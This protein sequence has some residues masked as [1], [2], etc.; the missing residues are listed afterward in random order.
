MVSLACG[1]EFWPILKR[2]FGERWCVSAYEKTSGELNGYFLRKGKDPC[3][4]CRE[5]EGL[6][7]LSCISLEEHIFDRNCSQ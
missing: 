1:G 4:F 7:C 5:T 6:S 2:L 3:V